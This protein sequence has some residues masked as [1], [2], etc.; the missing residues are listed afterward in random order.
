MNIF[1][2]LKKALILRS[3]E[4]RRRAQPFNAQEAEGYTI[5]KDADEFQN[6][7]YY[8]SCHDMA[9][10]S[11]LIRHAQRGTAHIEVWF[12]YRDAAEI[13]RAHV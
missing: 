13:G 11:L 4:K 9:G 6:N 10:A 3:L 8:F 1:F 7:S 2:S 12:A 5:P